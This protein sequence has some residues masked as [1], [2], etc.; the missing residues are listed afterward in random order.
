MSGRRS[1]LHSA[2][3]ALL[4]LVFAGPLIAQANVPTPASVLGFE[5]GAD[6]KLARY[7]ESIDWFRRLDAAS[8][9]VQ[10]IDVGRTS[11]GRPWTLALISSPQNLANLERWRDIAQQLARADGLTDE[12]ARALARE[13][14]ALVDISGGLH[15]SEVAGAQ[16]TI[17]LAYDLVS[18]SSEPRTKAILDNVVLLLWPSLNPDGQDIVVDWYR[19]NVGGPYETS[20]LHELYQKYI[21]HDN[22]RDA[23]MLNVV[24]SRVITRAWRHWEP[25]II[26][27]HHQSSPF[28]TRIW[29]PPF[30]EPVAP[31]APALIAREINA[32]GMLMA[33]ALEQNGQPGATHMGTG[34]DA[35]Y[36]GYID[37]L[38][39][40]QNI[41]AY[42]TETALYRYA[43]PYF[44]T[45]EDYPPGMRDFRPQSLYSSP[46]KGGWW[47]LRDAV[48]YMVTA[49]FAVLDYAAKYRED[50]LY[51]RYQAGRD[52]ILRY[53]T[54]PPYAY[55]VPQSQRDPVAAV[56]LLRRLAFN[57]IRV[58]QL[59]A[60]AVDNGTTYARGTWVIPMDQSYAELVRQLFDVQTYPDLREFPDGPPEQPYDA[61]GWTLPL[62]MDVRVIAATS[63]LDAAFTTAMQPLGAAAVATPN[64]DDAPFASNPVAAAIVAPPGRITGSG[65]RVS[66]DPAH[67]NAFRIVHRALAA[68]GSVRFIEGSPGSGGASGTTGRY[69]I[70]GIASG[71]MQQWVEELGVQ[72]ERTGA[73]GTVVR[74]RTALY[75]PWRAS[76]DEGWTRWLFDEYGIAYTTVTNADIQNGQLHDRFDVIVLAS[77]PP[78][79]LLNGFTAG[80]VP[81]RYAGGIADSGV[82]AL[83]AFVRAGGTLV[84]FN[85]SS[86]F[87]IEQLHLPVRNVVQGVNRREFFGN[88]SILEVQT[89]PSHPVMAGMPARANVFF[90]GSPVFTTRPGFEGV[91]LAKYAARGSPLRSGYLLGERHLNGYAAAV[92]VRHGDGHV[93]LI[94]FRPQWR[95]QP[96]GTFRIVFNAALFGAELAGRA[97]GSAQFWSVPDTATTGVSGAGSFNR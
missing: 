94:G 19:E 14:R 31:R 40:F 5:P 16:H 6:F 50:I 92:D 64:G 17:Q 83:D 43:T 86:N 93:I 34:F 75:K 53:R 76:M 2:G 77:D 52:A 33:Q 25:Q 69:A 45:L 12:Q 4:G 21:G 42:W 82:R 28:P 68:G 20:P 71:T 84:C 7:E 81:P 48:D 23:Y 96:A 44:Y 90:D 72:A 63:P 80:S 51:N 22:N 47:R 46:W 38:P 49:S 18:K 61:A 15:A 74:A 67:T 3:S 58:A 37:Y 57:G 97:G 54:E 26:H 10:L 27:V 66:L 60:D 62:Q 9:Y 30:A 78:A 11:E 87:A 36:P 8:D 39:I 1:L 35:W 56:E 24:E 55:I 95:G 29:L 65:A 13:G 79:A 59:E 89:D 70:D 85:Q 41:A 91:I 73:T 88:G 32:I